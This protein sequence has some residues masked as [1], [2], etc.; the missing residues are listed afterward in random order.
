MGTK[1]VRFIISPCAVAN[2]AECK[3]S[4][5]REWLIRTPRKARVDVW[6]KRGCGVCIS[7]SSIQRPIKM[8]SLQDHS[9]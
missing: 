8:T 1:I 2:E 3:E 7:N 4:V 5:R 9:T 6:F